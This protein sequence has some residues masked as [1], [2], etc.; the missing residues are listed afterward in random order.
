M[1]SAWFETNGR[2]IWCQVSYMYSAHIFK[3]AF[4]II[5]LRQILYQNNQSTY[6]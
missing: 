5:Q 6:M 2:L 3:H 1:R 4:V